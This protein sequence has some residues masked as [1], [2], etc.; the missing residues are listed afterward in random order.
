MR[1]QIIR[2]G[3]PAWVL[4]ERQRKVAEQEQASP[5]AASSEEKHN[6]DNGKDS[7][8]PSPHLRTDLSRQDE[9]L[10]KPQERAATAS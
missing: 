9:L 8:Q 5:G 10:R 4:T 7:R 2:N 6:V 3:P 1:S